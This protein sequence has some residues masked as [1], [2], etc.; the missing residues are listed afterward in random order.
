MPSSSQ[1]VRCTSRTGDSSSGRSTIAYSEVI[2]GLILRRSSEALHGLGGGVRAALDLEGEH[3]VARRVLAHG[4]SYV[5]GVDALD[6][7]R[8]LPVPEGG[9]DVDLGEV[10][11]GRLGVAVRSEERRVGKE[12]V[13]QGGSRWEPE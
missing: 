12:S 11:A 5:A 1:P 10:K 6:D 13:S 3:L 8:Q 4:A 2:G 7:A 9:V